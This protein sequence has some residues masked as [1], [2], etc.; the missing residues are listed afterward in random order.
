M[1]LTE[2]R[3]NEAKER[4]CQRQ[5]APFWFWC[6]GAKSSHATH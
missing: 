2:R 6:W 4:L 3:W 1:F 5:K